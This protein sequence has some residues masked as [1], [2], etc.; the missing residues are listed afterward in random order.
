MKITLYWR[1]EPHCKYCEAAENFLKA[2]SLP[3]EKIDVAK[4]D[5]ALRF[6]KEEKGHRSVPQIYFDGRLLVEG[7]YDE[8]K[9]L[10]KHEITNRMQQYVNSKI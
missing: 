1:S 10:T 5:A 3:Y 9:K 4:D 6:L 8:L 2:N 7:G